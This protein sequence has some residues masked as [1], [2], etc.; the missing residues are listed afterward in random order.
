MAVEIFRVGKKRLKYL[1]VCE[2]NFYVA[3]H[4]HIVDYS[5]QRRVAASVVFEKHTNFMLLA[6]YNL[7]G[8]F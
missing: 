7:F 8:Y 5:H 6:A 4:H 3:Q 2:S 1:Y